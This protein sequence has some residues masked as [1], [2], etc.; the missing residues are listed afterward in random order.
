MKF[1]QSRTKAFAV[2]LAALL[3]ISFSSAAVAAT[4]APT[5]LHMRGAESDLNFDLVNKTGYDIKAVRISWSGNKEWSDDDDV[6]HGRTFGS[7]DTL[8]ITFAPKEAHA[9]WDIQV[10]WSDGTGTVEWTE[11]K[12]SDINTVT[13]HYDKAA[14]KTTAV[15]E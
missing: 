5:G 7:G 2:G 10:E 13:L 15:V 1:L 12:L 8:K 3:V 14:D 9:H 6:L 11:L 4:P